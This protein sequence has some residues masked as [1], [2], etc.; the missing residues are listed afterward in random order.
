MLYR[1]SDTTTKIGVSKAGDGFALNT[2]A[3]G[4]FAAPV[5]QAAD[6]GSVSR[7]YL[8]EIEHWAYCIRNPSPENRPRCYPEVALGDAVIAL[9][10]NQALKQSASGN[11]GFIKFDEFWFDREND[12][13][14]D[15][16]DPKAERKKMEE[17]LN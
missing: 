12:A 14:P 7:G 5:A 2:Q 10:S 8:E 3:S 11:G 6:S 1:D 9:T 17:F 15:G 4:N 16:S 13:T